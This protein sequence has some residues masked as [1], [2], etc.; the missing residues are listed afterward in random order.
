M[1]IASRNV[2]LA[3]ALG[4]STFFAQA[5]DSEQRR[6]STTSGASVNPTINEEVSKS[7]PTGTV[8]IGVTVDRVTGKQAVLRPRCRPVP[9]G[10]TNAWC[11]PNPPSAVDCT[12]DGY[13][14]LAWERK[15]ANGCWTCSGTGRA[16]GAPVN[17][18]CVNG[19]TA[20]GTVSGAWMPQTCA[21][22]GTI[23]RA[24]DLSMRNASGD[25]CIYASDTQC[26]YQSVPLATC[27]NR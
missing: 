22:E 9:T 21:S 27:N 8:L 1:L 4:L 11:N 20:G 19:D 24:I 14:Q 13:E 10:S 26:T 16:C 17:C 7:C 2:F 18:S 25:S 5:G 6:T 15:N 12:C 3:V 23:G